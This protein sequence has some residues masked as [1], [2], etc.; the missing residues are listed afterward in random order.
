[1]HRCR[2][3]IGLARW[4]ALLAKV[5]STQFFEF[6]GVGCGST[7]ARYP[8]ASIWSQVGAPRKLTALRRRAFPITDTELNAIAALAMTGLSR[9]PNHG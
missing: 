6:T 3:H 4:L 1:M 7:L 9:M 5:A 8:D 2:R